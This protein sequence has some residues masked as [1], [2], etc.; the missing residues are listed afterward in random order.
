MSSAS[1][2][3]RIIESEHQVNRAVLESRRLPSPI[4]L[5]YGRWRNRLGREIYR[6]RFCPLR[7]SPTR[8]VA[9]VLWRGDV[10]LDIGAS[11]GQMVSLASIAVGPLGHV[12]AFEPR[13]SAFRH[14]QLLRAAYGLTNVELFQFLVGDHNGQSLLFESSD[15]PSSSSLSHEWAGGVSRA[16]PMT[17]LDMWAQQH[18]VQ[19]VD[20]VKIDVEGAEIQVLRGGLQFL[21]Q[22]QPLVIMEIRDREV[23]RRSF[24][25]DVS[26]LI[27]L[28]CSIGYAEFYSLRAGGLA[29]IER[30]TDI[31]LG[32]SDMLALCPAKTPHVRV[33][34]TL[35]SNW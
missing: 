30:E 15:N 6:S 28:L 11:E 19:R 13:E 10:Y 8:I 9:S 35:A 3:L 22:T 31:L 1:W 2:A 14:L 23:R 34:K 27:G 4:K 17:T 25:Y 21:R 33:V 7:T 18:S 26:D 5:L 12:Y 16:Y 20:L 24:G 29:R 32:D